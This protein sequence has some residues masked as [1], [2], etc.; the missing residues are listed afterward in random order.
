MKNIQKLALFLGGSFIYFY[1]FCH[2]FAFMAH[3]LGIEIKPYTILDKKEYMILNIIG[4]L[5]GILMLFRIICDESNANKIKKYVLYE[6]WAINIVVRLVFQH[7]ETNILKNVEN[8]DY[9]F[10]NI[11]SFFNQL[12]DAPKWRILIELGLRV[13][14]YKNLVIYRMD[15]GMLEG[16]LL[17][18]KFQTETEIQHQFHIITDISQVNQEYIC[19]KI[20]TSGIH[21]P[22]QVSFTKTIEHFIK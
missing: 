17:Y 5:I 18:Y 19:D 4:L 12:G 6:Q 3:I 15:I 1:V 11:S 8:N 22:T 10:K 9:L 2:I 16:Y 14:E 20:I 7:F 21:S 13:E